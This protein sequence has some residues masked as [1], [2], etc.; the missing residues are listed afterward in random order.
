MRAAS[1]RAK[2]ILQLSVIVLYTVEVAQ[3]TWSIS[4]FCTVQ[5]TGPFWKKINYNLYSLHKYTVYRLVNK[6]QSYLMYH[7]LVISVKIYKI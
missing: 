4:Y 6:A 2:H 5:L 7:H 3:L 1:S